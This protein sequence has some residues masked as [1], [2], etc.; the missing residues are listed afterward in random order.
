MKKLLKVIVLLSAALV[1]I[2]AVVLIA[3]FRFVQIG[4]LRRFLVSEIERQTRLRVS[5]G[6]AELEMGKVLGISFSD[7][8]LM[9]PESG[10]PVVTAQNAVVRMA[11]LPLLERRMVFDEVRLFRPTVRIERDE[12]GRASLSGLLAYFP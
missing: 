9:E 10:R 7:L 2:L 1:A 8:V 11:L 5:V 6:E 3:L 12:Q 4:E